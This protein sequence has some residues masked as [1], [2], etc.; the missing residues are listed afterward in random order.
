VSRAKAATRFVMR[1]GT[2]CSSEILENLEN[3]RS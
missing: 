3:W 1:A 2:N